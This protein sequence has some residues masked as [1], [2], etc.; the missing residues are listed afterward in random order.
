MQIREALKGTSSRGQASEKRVCAA[1]A[2]G[3][4]ESMGADGFETVQALQCHRDCLQRR[5]R[6]LGE[7]HE[8]PQI[9]TKW[10]RL[11]RPIKLATEASYMM[12]YAY[13]NIFYHLPKTDKAASICLSRDVRNNIIKGLPVRF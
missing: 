13:T 8:E 7:N 2:V 12:L 10:L 1:S 11:Y 9:R 5:R 6:V 4:F 3:I